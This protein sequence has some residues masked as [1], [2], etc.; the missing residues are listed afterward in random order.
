MVGPQVRYFDLSSDILSEFNAEVILKEQRQGPALV[1][2]E[3]DICYATT[4]GSNRLD[5]VVV[6]LK[7][8]GARLVGA[9]QSQELKRPV[10]VNL[11]RRAA[12]GNYSFTGSV[13]SGNYSEDVQSTGN[14]EM[15]EPEF[16]E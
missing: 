1:S 15:T 16:Q 9:A 11:M 14:V 6:P 4:P 5:R 12:G 3:L 13:K 2:A 7:V 10:A 8:E